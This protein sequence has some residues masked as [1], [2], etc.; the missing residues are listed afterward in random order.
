[1]DS[2]KAIEHKEETHQKFMK[3]E[4]QVIDEFKYWNS[5]LNTSKAIKI[6]L[7]KELKET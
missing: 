2:S 1:M 7:T 4:N 3:D 5:I 6:S